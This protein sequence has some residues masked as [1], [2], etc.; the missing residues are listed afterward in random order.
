MLDYTKAAV[1]KIV[2]DLKRV[3]YIFNIVI[4]SLS[5][6]YLVYAICVSAGILWANIALLTFSVVF[7]VFYLITHNKN[8][9]QVRQIY[10]ATKRAC[11]WIKL[12][13]RAFTL[14]IMMYSLYAA[15]THTTAV[16]VILT[17]LMVVG[18]TLQVL[19]EIVLAFAESRFEILIAG[20]QADFENAIKPVQSVGNF[21][22]KVTGQEVEPDKEPT[23]ARKILDKRVSEVRAER[24][25]KK[26]EKRGFF[27]RF[28][29]KN[30]EAASDESSNGQK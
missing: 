13:I 15:T 5:I 18:W 14:G 16:S 7:F 20:I 24:K 25:K 9:K 22:K 3:G 1:A 26:E 17:A 8:G 27:S 21:L 4:Q 28:A 10:K 12:S 23:R 6:V 11:K 19:L 29:K 2:D 30:P